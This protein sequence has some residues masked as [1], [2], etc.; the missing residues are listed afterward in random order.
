MKVLTVFLVA[1]LAFGLV[2][3]TTV[4][5]GESDFE[6]ATRAAEQHRQRLTQQKLV[7]ILKERAK[8]CVKRK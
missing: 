2:A 1:A 7:Q 8:P 4:S 6:K 3:F 5:S